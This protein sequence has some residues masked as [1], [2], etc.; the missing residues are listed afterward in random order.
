MKIYHL[1]LYFILVLLGLWEITGMSMAIYHNSSSNYQIQKAMEVS[2][3]MKSA[4][5]EYYF[6]NQKLGQNNDKLG[7]AP[8]GA[9]NEYVISSVVNN[10]TISIQLGNNVKSELKNSLI[11]YEPHIKND[12]ISW[13]CSSTNV[14]IDKKILTKFC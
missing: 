1:F 8:R 11:I 12:N 4:I 5:K 6:E 13:T 14:N 10:G 3:V 9:T 2:W 7:L